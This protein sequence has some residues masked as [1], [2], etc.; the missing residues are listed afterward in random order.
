M[1]IQK[2]FHVR[3]GLEETKTALRNVHLYRRQLNGLKKAVLTSDGV[4]QFDCEMPSGVR[5][6]CVVAELPTADP[7]QALFQSTAGNVEISGLIEFIPVRD[8]LT[9]VQLTFEYSFK[10]AVHVLLDRVTNCTEH[11]LVSQLQRLEAWLD[12]AAARL[13]GEVSPHFT[14][15]LPQLAQ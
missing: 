13:G 9:E 5:A 12:S 7:N 15:H 4:G 8:N 11:F 2:V 3:H 14:A 6:H 1:L 10:S